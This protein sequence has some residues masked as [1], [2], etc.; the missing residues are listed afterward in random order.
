MLYVFHDGARKFNRAHGVKQI[1][2]D[3]NRAR[4]L[5]CHVG[6]RADSN[7]QVRLRQSRRVVYAVADHR[8]FF[9]LSLK[10]FNRLR[11]VFR[12]NARDNFFYAEALSDCVR[13]AFVVARQHDDIDAEIF[14]FFDGLRGS[15]FLDVGRRDYP[16]NFFVVGKN[17]GRLA[18]LSERRNFFAKTF[19]IE[20]KLRQK[21]FVARE[22]FDAVNF[23]AN[24]F[25]KNRLKIF[26]DG[27]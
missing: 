20:S 13:G 6:A 23:C 12:K 27:R 8:N 10:I 5:D 9:S 24:A 17:Y 1:V 7:A 4:A 25:S 21:I 15:F 3:E 18:F 16:Q 14:K 19:Q 22:I 26:R 2:S 11:F